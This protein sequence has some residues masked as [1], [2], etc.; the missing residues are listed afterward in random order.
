[1]LE[2]N[3]SAV[4]APAWLNLSLFLPPC[5]TTGSVVEEE[6]TFIDFLHCRRRGE[7][8]KKKSKTANQVRCCSSAWG[9]L[10]LGVKIRE[11]VL[12]RDPSLPKSR[13][14]RRNK[15]KETNK[16]QSPQRQQCACLSFVFIHC[17]PPT[18]LEDACRRS[19]VKF[20]YLNALKTTKGNGL[21]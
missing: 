16:R 10:G 14:G 2:E 12:G 17:A 11:T 9:S 15:N 1:M 8:K 13:R 4:R 7:R 20:L 6:D 18:G 3:R 5:H 21:R 19:L